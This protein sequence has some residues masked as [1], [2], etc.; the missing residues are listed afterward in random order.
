[1]S[2]SSRSASVVLAQKV[3]CYN[4]FSF[5]ACFILL[6]LIFFFVLE[7]IDSKVQNK[8]QCDS[9]SALV[10]H[11]SVLQCFL[12]NLPT[13]WQQQNTSLYFF[14]IGVSSGT[15]LERTL[16]APMLLS[17]Y[18]I[19]YLALCTQERHSLVF[20]FHFSA[21]KNVYCCMWSSKS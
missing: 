12:L 5:S 16:P 11:R 1:M 17:P 19:C 7:D 14:F 10:S 4:G 21:S 18:L 8:H 9:D 2:W 3:Q 15:K 6:S 20:S 13:G